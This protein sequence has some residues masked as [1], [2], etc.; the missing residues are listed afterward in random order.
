MPYS[1]LQLYHV[2]DV[3]GEDPAQGAAPAPATGPG[4]GPRPGGSIKERSGP[5][6]TS[7]NTIKI[8]NRIV[9]IFEFDLSH[10][11]HPQERRDMESEDP[12]R[13]EVINTTVAWIITLVA[14]TRL[15]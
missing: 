4:E 11:F 12:E 3:G 5:S 14:M 13:R 15:T 1:N 10:S 7:K 2:S 6:Q 8:L 9:H